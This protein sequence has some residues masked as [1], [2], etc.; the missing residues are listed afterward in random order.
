MKHN[1]PLCVS[2]ALMKE[3]LKMY[4][5]IP[6]LTFVLYF[7]TGIIPILS[8]ISNISSI[9][10]YIYQSLRN[11][12][13][14]YA[15]IMSAAPV[16][17]ALLMMGFLHKEAKALM[18]HAMP[19]S[20]SR[21]FNS[22]YMAGWLM[23]VLPLL[24]M[25][26]PYLLLSL[27]VTVLARIDVLYWLLSSVAVMTLF[28]SITVLAG[29]L[30]GTTVMN[31]L[32]AAVLSVIFPLIVR[33]AETYCDIFIA[34][35]YEMPDWL[36]CI[37]DNYNPLMNLVLRYRADASGTVFIVYFAAGVVLA[38]LARLIYKTRKLELIGTS[39]LSHIFEELVTYLVVFIGMS[40]FGL[41][42]WTFTSSRAVILLGMAV[43]MLVTF[44]V[45]KVI[46]N[47]SV[48]I[49]NRELLRSFGLYL[50]IAVVFV[51]LTVF[52]VAGF[53]RR[54]PE[55][56]EVEAVKMDDFVFTGSDYMIF[57]DS[58]PKGGAER[59]FTSAEDIEKIVS[60]HEYIVENQAYSGGLYSGRTE[61]ESEAAGA[62]LYD[63]EGNPVQSA[64]E[65]IHI[66]YK[67]SSGRTVE[68][69]YDVTL[70]DNI[71]AI[72]DELVTSEEYR[73]KNS[74]FTYID[75][76]N[77]S[78]VQLVS[79]E[80]SSDGS[81]VAVIDSRS[82]ITG[83]LEAWDADMASFG[84]QH[85]NLTVSAYTDLASIEISFKQPEKEKGSAGALWGGKKHKPAEEQETITLTINNYCENTI[86]Y[87]TESGYGRITGYEQ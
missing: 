39:T 40:A 65:Y 10:Y 87:L 76:D 12:N 33:I 53:T 72:I 51:A 58:N 29:T 60:L 48:R 41:M 42:M 46:V 23:C 74:V 83:L 63:M 8:N 17:T 32:A 5:Y 11:T 16:V 14:I 71:A 7:F 43:G 21:I 67:L 81:N 54:V 59:Y 73:A 36:Q 66:E 28:Y 82:M 45:V 50:V 30:T 37:A 84:Y 57:G 70:D 9:D 20:K 4:W 61:E 55:V 80:D 78:H 22:Y 19:F 31:I 69:M 77:V 49:F 15:L 38:V 25:V 26:V 86:L 64:N 35:F 27:K 13:V 85:N 2:G 47:R 3:I 56:S 1:N 79:Y 18:L 6:V 75:V 24:A 52:D 34:G 62:E 44:F 68:R